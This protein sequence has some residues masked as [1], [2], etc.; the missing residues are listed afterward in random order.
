VFALWFVCRFRTFWIN[1]K[2]GELTVGYGS[3]VYRNMLISTRLD[4]LSPGNKWAPVNKCNLVRHFQHVSFGG[5]GKAVEFKDIKVGKAIL[6]RTSAD[7]PVFAVGF[8]VDMSYRYFNQPNMLTL[9]ARAFAVVVEVQSLG[10]ASIGF[11]KSHRYDM[12]NQD[13]DAY[14]IVLH[15]AHDHLHKGDAVQPRSLIRRAIGNGRGPVYVSVPSSLDKPTVSPTEFRPF[16]IQLADG[17]LSVGSGLALGHN[18]LMSAD[19]HPFPQRTLVMGFGGDFVPS[20]FRVLAAMSVAPEDKINVNFQ[21]KEMIDGYQADSSSA[22]PLSF[23]TGTPKQW[24]HPVP[25]SLHATCNKFYDKC[26]V[27]QYENVVRVA[28]ASPRVQWRTQGGYCMETSIQIAAMSR[29]MYANV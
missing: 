6:P 13:P 29:G 1:W 7:A 15:Q 12:A 26:H 8:D 3:H 10:D 25:R 27:P 24:V 4:A 28:G 22:A 16:W 14:E 11:L 19:V 2:N 9:S 5:W 18:V 17:K 23:T 20:A 21:A